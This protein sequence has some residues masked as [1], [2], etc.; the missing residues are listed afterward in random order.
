V[1]RFRY[2][3]SRGQAFTGLSGPKTCTRQGV[4]SKSNRVTR[5]A[6]ALQR[7]AR[8]NMYA[9]SRCLR[10]GV[11][12]TGGLR[13]RVRGSSRLKGSVTGFRLYRRGFVPRFCPIAA[14]HRARVSR[15]WKGPVAGRVPCQMKSLPRFFTVLEGLR[16]RVSPLPDGL[17]ARIWTLLDSVCA[18]VLS[19]LDMLCAKV[20]PLLEGFRASLEGLCAMVSSLQE[21]VFRLDRMGPCEGLVPTGRAPCQGFLTT[22]GA[23]CQGFQHTRGR[24]A[25]V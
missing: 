15:C 4:R 22:A 25:S 18:N 21:P 1:R 9:S 17:R 24:R 20:S 10:Q 23:P 11:V 2:G 12:A 6:W 13:L 14:Q 16:A 7:A 19:L 8:Q 3:C 5:K